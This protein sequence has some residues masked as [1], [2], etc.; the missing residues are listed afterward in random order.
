MAGLPSRMMAHIIVTPSGCWEWTGSLD[1]HGYGQV[2]FDGA[3]RLAHRVVYEVIVGPIPTGYQLDHLCHEAAFCICGPRCPHRR[4]VNPA[5]LT[6]VTNKQN[7]ERGALAVRTHCVNG[8][9]YSDE[10]TYVS[11]TRRVCRACDR[12]RHRKARGMA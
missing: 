7:S 10:N 9:P 2:R 1:R 8:H 4:C 3:T 6:P 5:H 11:A 12:E